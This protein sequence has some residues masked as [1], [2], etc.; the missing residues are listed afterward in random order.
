M[1]FCFCLPPADIHLSCT[2]SYVMSY[3]FFFQIL[4]P[5]SLTHLLLCLL[6]IISSLFFHLLRAAPPLSAEMTTHAPVAPTV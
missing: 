2:F 4:T 5:S 3:P 6:L 1:F